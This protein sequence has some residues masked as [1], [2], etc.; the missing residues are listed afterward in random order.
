M[1]AAT[2]TLTG[3][4]GSDDST[5]PSYPPPGYTPSTIVER[6]TAAIE[7]IETRLSGVARG[8]KAVTF[9]KLAW[10]H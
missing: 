5:E 7:G 10:I 3:C 6:Q 8:Y 4:T 2:D 9:I 1:C